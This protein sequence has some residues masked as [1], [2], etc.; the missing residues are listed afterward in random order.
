MASSITPCVARWIK[1]NRPSSPE[2]ARRS[3][4]ARWRRSR[5]G[6]EWADRR[7]GRCGRAP[8]PHGVCQARDGGRHRRIGWTSMCRRLICGDRSGAG[9]RSRT[10]PRLPGAS[11]RCEDGRLSRSRPGSALPPVRTSRSS[12]D[13]ASGRCR[14]AR[15]LRLQPMPRGIG[16]GGDHVDQQAMVGHGP[17]SL[18]ASGRS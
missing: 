10:T 1:P 9:L 2:S 3:S 12:L 8:R 17:G 6:F 14:P 15:H 18:D 13:S 5:A 11:S 16:A 7:T 4:W